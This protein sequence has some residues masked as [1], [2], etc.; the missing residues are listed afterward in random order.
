MQ[1]LFSPSSIAVVGASA[2]PERVSGL[3]IK[4]LQDHGYG[5]ELFPVNPNH[6]RV[7]GLRC[8]PDVDSLPET[9]DLVLVIVPAGAVVEVVEASLERGSENVLIVSSGFSETGTGEGERA[10]RR[11]ADLAAEHDATVVGPNS[12]G[13]IEFHDRVAASFTPAL[14]RESLLAGE[15]SFVT[16]SGAFGGALTTM[17]QDEG[18][19]LSKWIA[20]GNE[21]ATGALDVLSFLAGDDRTGVVAGYVEGF[22]DGRKLVELKR[23]DAGIDLP[24]VLLKVGRSERGRSAAASHTGTVASAHEVYEAVFRETGV[25]SVDDVDLF[26]DLTRA[27]SLLDALPGDRLGVVTTSGGAGVH[28]ADVADEEGLSLP[29]LGEG[30]SDR[31]REFIPEFGSALNPVDLTG[32]VVNSKEAFSECLRALFED[33]G[34]GTIVLQITNASGESAEEY[35]ERVVE[36]ASGYEKPLLL[37]WTGG[38]EKESALGR[39]RDAGVPVFENPA[40]C[41]RAV[42]SLARFAESKPRLRAAKDLPARTPDFDPD[43]GDAR[44]VLAETDAKALLAEF[45]VDVPEEVLVT[46]P[47]ETGEAVER[48]GF[49]AVAK[50]V[51]PDLPHRDRVGGVRL[52]IEDRGALD[53]AC[54]EL[55]DLARDLGVD[56]QGVSVQEQVEGAGELAMGILV[57][58]DFGP[59]C[60]LGRGGVDIEETGDV[61]FRTIPVA[62]EQANSM[63]DEF[64]LP[65]ELDAIQHEAVVEAVVSLSELYLENPW[66]R[67]GDVNPLLVTP[68]GVTAVD[69]LFVGPDGAE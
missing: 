65:I 60:M 51:A 61:T 39:Y 2:D 49:P 36:V 11:I 55:F 62:P 37:C 20:T 66:I 34:I 67:E 33:D 63:L 35:A 12:Q 28:I 18:V 64:D 57:D 38:V 59:V 42:A 17:L 4:Y 10:E 56:P 16:Q 50:L 6:D 26:V 23:T 54:R 69:G 58:P 46:D 31:I 13:V 52:G 44:S 24:V 43:S 8:Y 9:P 25:M 14:R 7:A 21:A 48:V 27:V 68:D 40:R 30:T 1:T 19:G 45:G 29:S 32:Q 22:D 15:V 3:P 53:A 5:G 41:V 47:D